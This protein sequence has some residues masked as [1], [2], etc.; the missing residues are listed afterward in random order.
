MYY[1]IRGTSDSEAWKET[2]GALEQDAPRKV[3][4]E[5]VDKGSTEE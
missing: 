1:E 2:T 5:V 3:V 4:D